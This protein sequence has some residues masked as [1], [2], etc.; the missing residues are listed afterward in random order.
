MYIEYISVFK[1][2]VSGCKGG[3]LLPDNFAFQ[4]PCGKLCSKYYWKIRK[5]CS[6]FS[7]CILFYLSVKFHFDLIKV[8]HFISKCLCSQFGQVKHF[9]SV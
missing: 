3:N 6:I 2:F 7:N 8:I 4:C 9:L 5:Y 1:S